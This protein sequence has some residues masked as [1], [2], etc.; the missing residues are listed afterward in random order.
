MIDE[1]QGTPEVATEQ[2]TPAT[3]PEPGLDTTT[4][5]SSSETTAD[6]TSDA[7]L[8]LTVVNEDGTEETVTAEEA[9]RGW[10][11]ER[12]YTQKTMAI[13]ARERELSERAQR[14]ETAVTHSEALTQALAAEFQ[15]EFAGVDWGALATNDPAEYVR[16]RHAYDQRQGKLQQAFSQLQSAKQAQA[17]EAQRA[18]EM[19][20]QEQ[21][22]LLLKKVPEWRDSKK[23][24][25]ETAKLREALTAAGY[26][27]DEISGVTDHRAVIL[28]RKAALYD[29][30]VA[31]TPKAAAIPGAPPPVPKAPTKAVGAKDPAQ[32]TDREFAEWR[33]RQIAQRR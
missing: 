7:P 6:E 11:R 27:P 13:A 4:P 1:V 20:L 23:F 33:N 16:K 14:M 22:E 25:A 5:E 17:V 9:R 28:A 24:A 32:M 30:L 26:G 12:D 21:R 31:K 8:T 29:E 18:Q 15:A 3:E 2:V 10:L 19:T